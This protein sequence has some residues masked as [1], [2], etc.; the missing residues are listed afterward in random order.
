M[1]SLARWIGLYLLAVLACGG[2]TR[3][4]LASG[5]ADALWLLAALHGAAGYVL[6][7]TLLARLAWN[8]NFATLAV[9]AKTK[10]KALL[11]WP[12]VYPVLIL[13]LALCRY[14]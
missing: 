4:I 13:Q 3:L 5:H 12:V 14:L 6:N 8:P 1:P 10:L 2:G 9:V 11:F 7:R